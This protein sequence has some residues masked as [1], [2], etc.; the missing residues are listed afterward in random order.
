[1]RNNNSSVVRYIALFSAIYAG[2]M[3]VLNMV[4]YGFDFDIGSSANMAILFG[5]AYGTVS[6]FV[7]DH[8]RAPSKMEK[9]I[10]IWGCICSAFVVSLGIVALFLTLAGDSTA[11]D[12]LSLLISQLSA[13]V[14]LGIFLFVTLMHY[15]VLYVIYSWGAKR[16]AKKFQPTQS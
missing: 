7:S 16:F 14:W 5:A 13:S 12:Q 15:A 1:M 2:L 8:K 10:L 4:V 6:K 3:L 11:W 9:Q